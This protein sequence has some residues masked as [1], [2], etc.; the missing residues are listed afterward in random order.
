[1]SPLGLRYLPVA[2]MAGRGSTGFVESV[3][4]F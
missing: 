2:D 1:M 4:D 3:A